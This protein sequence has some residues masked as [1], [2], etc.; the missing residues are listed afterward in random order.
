[1]TSPQLAHVS[2]KDLQKA[3]TS[4]RQTQKDHLPAWLLLDFEPFLA[5]IQR[6][7][8]ADLSA[9]IVDAAV[10]A[11]EATFEQRLNAK[12]REHNLSDGD[13]ERRE[14]GVQLL[15]EIRYTTWLPHAHR[16]LIEAGL[17]K[18]AGTLIDTPIMA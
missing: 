4:I 16:I 15:R 2:Q 1:M 3:L 18:L 9:E 17:S 8:G 5:E 6:Q 7:L 11:S 12:L 14:M 13:D 10:E